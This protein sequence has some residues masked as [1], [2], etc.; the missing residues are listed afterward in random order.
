MQVSGQ[1]QVLANLTPLAFVKDSVY[2]PESINNL[3]NTEK[4][5]T[6]RNLFPDHSEG[7]HVSD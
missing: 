3:W 4:H 2:A 1:L 6:L 7:N 5:P